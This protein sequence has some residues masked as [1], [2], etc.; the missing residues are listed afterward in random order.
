MSQIH[1]HQLVLAK[2]EA[3]GEA[4]AAVFFRKGAA[5]ISKWKG[6]TTPPDIAAAQLAL[7]DYFTDKAVPPAGKLIATAPDAPPPQ[8]H[9]IPPKQEGEPQPFTTTL[10]DAKEG[11]KFTQPGENEKPKEQRRKIMILMPTSSEKGIMAVTAQAL[12]GSW[13]ATIDDDRIREELAHLQIVTD[14][15]AHAARNE[16]ASRFLKSGDEWTFWM[17][18]DMIVS[19]GNPAWFADKTGV[20]WPAEFSGQAYIN[21]LMSH[22]KS[23]VGCAY[24]ERSR[25]GRMLFAGGMKEKGGADTELMTSIR[26]GPR[27][28]LVPVDWIGFGCIAVHRKV[29]EDMIERCPEVKPAKVGGDYRFFNPLPEASS[30]G[31]ED[32]AFCV[33]AKRAGHQTYMDLACIAGHVGM[34]AYMP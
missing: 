31:G 28:Q 2:I 18:R 34:Q 27:N 16:L 24:S 1:L 14:T 12:L 21:R 20:K 15:N 4:E 33:R 22:G 13:K 32:I 19:F 29:F 6:G 3:I 25:H 17:D 23:I 30:H 7:D 11:D 10:G 5:T 26:S 9:T 8:G